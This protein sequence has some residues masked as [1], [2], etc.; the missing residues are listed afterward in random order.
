MMNENRMRK[1]LPS[2]ICNS[3]GCGAK[4]EGGFIQFTSTTGTV[5]SVFDTAEVAP[6]SLTLLVNMSIAPE[7]MEYLVKGRTMVLNT[8]NGL[9][10]RVLEASSMSMLILST[11]ADMDLTK[12]GYVIAR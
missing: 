2:P 7:S 12:Y 1:P 10:P 11:A 9:A 5:L 4:G 6:V 8:P 3:V